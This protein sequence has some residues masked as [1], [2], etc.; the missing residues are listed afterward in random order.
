M[1]SKSQIVLCTASNCSKPCT[2]T[3]KIFKAMD[4]Q[5]AGAASV[6]LDDTTWKYNTKVVFF[7]FWRKLSSTERVK[8]NKRILADVMG[9][10]SMKARYFARIKL[11]IYTEGY[12]VR[13]VGRFN[14]HA[15]TEKLA[16][17]HMREFIRLRCNA[18]CTIVGGVTVCRSII[19]NSRRRMIGRLLT[20]PLQEWHKWVA[21]QA[22][23][24]NGAAC[25]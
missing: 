11:A 19:E 12:I 18:S 1:L 23:E 4:R 7:N 9:N 17:A 24:E 10:Y 16:F 21:W 13:T 14:K 20:K 6:S 8:R 3:R 15:K 5:E 22:Q 25:H 2:F